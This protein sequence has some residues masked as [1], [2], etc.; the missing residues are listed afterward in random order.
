[1]GMDPPA[2]LGTAMVQ[3]EVPAHNPMAAAQAM[4]AAGQA[5]MGLWA[6]AAAGRAPF[7]PPALTTAANAVGGG[8]PGINPAMF[9]QMQPWAAMMPGGM[10]VAQMQEMQASMMQASMQNRQQTTAG[11]TGDPPVN[12][13]AGVGNRGE[14][15]LDVDEHGAASPS[16]HP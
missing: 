13:D 14:Q 15:N 9:Y 2:A 4:V 8:P 5:N 6:A 12:S 7:M 3:P 10:N 11:R 1:M 16:R